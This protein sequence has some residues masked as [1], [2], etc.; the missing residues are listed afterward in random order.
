MK[1][2]S[3]HSWSQFSEID[4]T[5]K[6][7]DRGRTTTR[8]FSL[9]L[10]IHSWT[11]ENKDRCSIR[12]VL[13][14]A[15]SWMNKKTKE[16]PF[17]SFWMQIEMCHGAWSL[18]AMF[19]MRRYGCYLMQG[20]SLGTRKGQRGCGGSVCSQWSQE[21]VIPVTESR[22]QRI[23]LGQCSTGWRIAVCRTLG[24]YYLRTLQCVCLCISVG[25]LFSR[26]ALDY[27]LWACIY[28]QE[29]G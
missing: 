28:V 4:L 17:L 24:Y 11:A 18:T 13:V 9:F 19:E 25:E 2:K 1:C 10:F 5:P 15:F 26:G 20:W 7:T 12:F 14:C 3:S 22:T 27:P 29:G 8:H 23:S 21:A 16:I 6:Y